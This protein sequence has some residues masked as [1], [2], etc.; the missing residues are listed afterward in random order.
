MR[1]S[2][3]RV[4]EG[5][6]E[7]GGCKALSNYMGLGNQRNYCV[8]GYKTSHK[9]I[10]VFHASYYVDIKPLEPCPKPLTLREV[11]EALGKYQKK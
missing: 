7:H 8:L 9:E 6:S 4:C 10:F 11:A 2:Q 3:K 1:I 5:K